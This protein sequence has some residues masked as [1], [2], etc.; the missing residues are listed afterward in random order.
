MKNSQTVLITGA[1]AGIGR[2][3]ALYLVRRGHHVI[4]TGRNRDALAAL[5]AEASSAQQAP[6]AA[7]AAGGRLDVVRLDVTDAASIAAACAEVAR[8]TDGRGLDA[9]INNAGYGM[10]VPVDVMTDADV[11]AQYET[12][13]FGLLA[14]TRA[15][16]PG[17]RARGRGRIINVSSVGGRMTV[18]FLGV[19][20]STKYAVESLSN[21]MRYELAPFGIRVSLIEPGAIR[22]NFATRTVD[23]TERYRGADSPYAEAFPIYDRL[24]LLAD[25]TAPGPD[26]VARA[27]ER[28]MTA[29]RPS[30][31]YVTPFSN[32]I[33][34]AMLAVLPTR[35]VDWVF[36]KV[37]GLTRKRLGG[38][39]QRALPP[40]RPEA[41]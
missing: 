7:R 40:A 13:V 23:G 29:R 21:A 4:A 41:A 1:T 35:L 14:V 18:P 36:G 24:R 3:A 28:A 20:N 27:M 8:L 16:V 39:S 33:L 6:G 32:R 9:L 37:T 10:A 19:Y 15:F 25:K 26:C 22:T 17:M 2:H 38:A 5:E 11:R 30:A 12:N 34:L 31:R